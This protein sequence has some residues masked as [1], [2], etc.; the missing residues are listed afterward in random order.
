MSKNGN[1]YSEEFKQ[2][3][4]VDLYKAGNLVSYLSCE[5]GVANVTIYK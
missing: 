1:R 2:Q 4:V 5:Y 3:I